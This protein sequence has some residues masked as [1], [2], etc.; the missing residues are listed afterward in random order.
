MSAPTRCREGAGFRWQRGWET[1]ALT[2]QGRPATRGRR[3]APPPP[4]GAL[5]PSPKP[6]PQSECWSG[7][8]QPGLPT[9]RA[10]PGLKGV[11]PLDGPGQP[12]CSVFPGLLG[13]GG[14]WGPSHGPGPKP[15][16]SRKE[17][18]PAPGER[19]TQLPGTWRPGPRGHTH[20]RH[21]FLRSSG[22]AVDQVPRGEGWGAKYGASR[23]RCT[24]LP[25]LAWTLP[26]RQGCSTSSFTDEE[27]EARPPGHS[28]AGHAAY[29]SVSGFWTQKRAD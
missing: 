27:P 23:Q 21:L 1:G 14:L 2:A 19:T 28:G 25:R 4:P 24:A 3:R 10:K 8:R 7:G 22:Q 12:P 6:S 18:E 5:P 9:G 15:P 16:T 26:S 20:S 13:G 29:S 17:A 11:Q